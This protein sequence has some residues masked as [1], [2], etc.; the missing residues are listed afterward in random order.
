LTTGAPALAGC[1]ARRTRVGLPA[2]PHEA[3]R[4]RVLMDAPAPEFAAGVAEADH[5]PSSADGRSLPGPDLVSMTPKLMRRRR[6]VLQS[7]R[8]WLLPVHIAL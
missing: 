2:A 6:F 8:H 4:V 1:R 3:G 5:S 7:R